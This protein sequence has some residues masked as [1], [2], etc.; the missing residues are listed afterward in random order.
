MGKLNFLLQGNLL[1][2]FVEE[3]LQ[4]RVLLDVTSI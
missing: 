3:N 2:L 1:P 4:S